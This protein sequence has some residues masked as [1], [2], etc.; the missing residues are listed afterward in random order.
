MSYPPRQRVLRIT[1][2]R[3]ERARGIGRV[4]ESF[5]EGE[6][7]QLTPKGVGKFGHPLKGWEAFPT[8]GIQQKQRH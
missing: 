2:R 7:P 5:M 1:E 6:A 8:R 4:R 3:H